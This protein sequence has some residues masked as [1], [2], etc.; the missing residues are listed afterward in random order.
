MAFTDH[1]VIVLVVDQVTP[2]GQCSH[3]LANYVIRSWY[4][5]GI[6]ASKPVPFRAMQWW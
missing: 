1:E 3:H 5:N 2:D 4:G 6:V